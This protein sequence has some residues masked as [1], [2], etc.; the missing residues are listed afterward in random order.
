MVDPKLKVAAREGKF[1]VMGDDGTEYGPGPFNSREEAEAVLADW[2]AYY[3][4][5]L[6]EPSGP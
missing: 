6:P 2:I 4:S 5:P 1:L 3:E